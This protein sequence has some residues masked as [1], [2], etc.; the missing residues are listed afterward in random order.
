MSAQGEGGKVDFGLR[1]LRFAFSVT[2][3]ESDRRIREDLRVE[4]DGFLR[5]AANGSG[6][7][8]VGRNHLPQLTL[9]GQHELP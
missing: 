3:D 1:K 6:E 9:P 4:A 2:A 7:E 5:Q 8:Q